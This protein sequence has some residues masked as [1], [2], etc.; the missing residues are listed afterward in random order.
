MCDSVT[1]THLTLKYISLQEPFLL[2]AAQGLWS[3]EHREVIQKEVIRTMTLEKESSCK[4]AKGQ[5]SW[6][7]LEGSTDGTS[8]EAPTSE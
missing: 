6:S 7:I 3:I 8:E 1:L 5:S 2:K 4:V